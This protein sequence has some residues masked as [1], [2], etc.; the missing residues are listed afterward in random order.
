MN[1]VEG[2]SKMSGMWLEIQKLFDV[3][4]YEKTS[5]CD[6]FSV[7]QDFIKPSNQNLLNPLLL[8]FGKP[9]KTVIFL[10]ELDG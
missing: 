7:A 2:T 3:I 4:V 5:N 10:R 6:N 8:I 9:R 1:H